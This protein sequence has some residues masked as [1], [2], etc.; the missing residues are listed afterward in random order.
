MFPKI[1]VKSLYLTLI[2]TLLISC[3]GQQVFSPDTTATSTPIAT[4]EASSLTTDESGFT[5][6]FTYDSNGNL[7]TS[8]DANGHTIEYEYDALN[9]LVSI[10]Y[11]GGSKVTYRYDSL[12]QRTSMTDSQ[13]TTSYEY[14]IHGQLV[15]VIHPNGQSLQY[16]YDPRGLL[17]QM[18][19]PDGSSSTFTWDTNGQLSTVQDVSGL[20]SY[21]Y[22]SGG[23]LIAR[24]LPNGVLT[25]YAYDDAS[26]LMSIQHSSASGELL[27]GFEYEFDAVGNRT[28]ERMIDPVGTQLTQYQYDSLNRLVGVTNPAGEM[29]T[30][31]YDEIGNRS[32]RNSSIM[33]ETTYTYN[34]LGQLTELN[35]PQGQVTFNYDS[36]GNLLE[37]TDMQ[38]QQTMEYAWDYNNRL[39]SQDNGMMQINYAY[40]GDG[41]LI[42]EST[43][44][45]EISNFLSD[46]L[47]SPGSILAEYD[48]TGMVGAS[49]LFGNTLI[50]ERNTNGTDSFFLEDGFGSI[51]QLVDDSGVT[52]GIGDLET[53][54]QSPGVVSSWDVALP[55]DPGGLTGSEQFSFAPVLDQDTIGIVGSEAIA[56]TSEFLF[57]ELYSAAGRQYGPLFEYGYGEQGALFGKQFGFV[58][59]G[60]LTPV[61]FLGDMWNLESSL[62]AQGRPSGSP[63]YIEGVGRAGLR[64]IYGT[65]AGGLGY[66]LGLGPVGSIAL[67][68]FALDV[69]DMNADWA[70]GLGRFYGSRMDRPYWWWSPMKWM[71]N[72][73]Y[74]DFLLNRGTT[75]IS[76]LS[77]SDYISINYPGDTTWDD[78]WNNDFLLPMC[79]PICDDFGGGGAGIGGVSLDQAAEVLV[80]LNEITGASFD[81]RTGQ[82]SLVGSQ[83]PSLPPMNMDDLVVAIR[84]IY[85]GGQD[86][87]VTMVP[88]DP[89]MQDITQRVEYFG[90]T[91][92][93]H[94]GMV[95][96]EADRY[97]KS[98]A[99][100]KDTLTGQ[101]V[102]PNVPGFK[103]ELDLLIEL[104]AELPWHRNWFVPGEIVISQSEDGRSMVFDKATIILQSRFFEFLPDGSMQDIPGSSPVTEQFTLFM[105]EHYDEFAA[106]KPE[107]AELQQLAKIVGLVRWLYDN[108]IPVD[109]SWVNDYQVAYVDTPHTT[110]GVIN[111]GSDDTHTVT[112]M[113]GVDYPTE[114]TYVEAVGDGTEGLATQVSSSRPADYPVSWEMESGGETL[115]AVAFNMAPVEIIGGYLPSV[116]DIS[117][118]LEGG[119]SATFTRMYNSLDLA[120]GSLGSGWS[121][122]IPTLNFQ[123]VPVLDSPSYTYTRAV[124]SLGTGIQSFTRYSD[125]FYYLEDA[126]ISSGKFGFTS[127][128]P[129]TPISLPE[130]YSLQS[131]DLD[132]TLQLLDAQGGSVDIGGFALLRQDGSV[133]SFDSSGNLT[134]QRNPAG[135]VV[136]YSYDADKLMLI[137]DATGQSLQFAYGSN[138]RLTDLV[139]S[140]GQAVHYEYDSAGNL[141]SVFEMTAIPQVGFAHNSSR[142]LNRITY[143]DR[144]TRNLHSLSDAT[145]I[146][147]VSYAYNSDGRL[148]RITTQN[149]QIV[150][151]GYDG[152]GRVISS[153]S[154]SGSW[155]T[156]FDTTSNMITYTDSNGNSITRQYDDQNRLLSETDLLGNPINYQYDP[157][158]ALTS[159][160]DRNGNTSRFM[161][162]ENGNL[163]ET[164]SPIGDRTMLGNYNEFGLPG[165]SIGPDN[166]VTL[167]EY[168]EAGRLIGMKSGLRVTDIA[169]DGS[170]G[171]LPEDPRSMS[172][173]YDAVGNLTGVQDAAG[174]VT[175]FSYDNLGNLMALQLP[176]D[177]G[178]VRQTYDERSRLV[179]I[180]DATGYQVDFGYDELDQLVSITTPAGQTQYLYNNGLVTAVT[181]P[182][183]NTIQ[184]G[185]DTIGRLTN[186]TEPGGSVT[187]YTYDASGN[188]LAIRNPQGGETQYTYDAAGRVTGI[189]N[190]PAPLNEPVVP[191]AAPI[192]P[193]KPWYLWGLGGGVVLLGAVLTF[194]LLKTKRRQHQTGSSQDILPS[195]YDADDPFKF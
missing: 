59:N 92:H 83:D 55:G 14:D 33:G 104:H 140:N 46:P 41:N 54:V 125:G 169:S 148:N 151:L 94:F 27:L 162:D 62:T 47:A 177:G 106:G 86:P 163:S 134:G 103:S 7:K 90:Q 159:F 6:L 113:G 144:S 91:E 191:E 184:Y 164:V 100:G 12:S 43:S 192:P 111:E 61:T 72:E 181:D 9:R 129:F 35:G 101:P 137:A 4:V 8:T 67:S 30:Y 71:S 77:T 166:E 38:S 13:G 116:T 1:L 69:A 85:G 187:T 132:Q 170:F 154:P 80:N 175:Q 18:E 45:G 146:P 79:P 121:Q 34:E 40:N 52:F 157:Q 49:L 136:T 139:T 142:G 75:P 105:N 68:R 66:T 32:A 188:L 131:G 195:S 93:T 95:M 88:V 130:G 110:P 44:S 73:Q 48:D 194:V 107:L 173:R 109:L 26:R 127:G 51:R 149:G 53:F 102:A 76:T 81:P 118:P 16:A 60:I 56:Q 124:I 63:E 143:T 161:Y 168:D 172:Y 150:E 174:L 99:S 5:A 117:V 87:G 185:Y 17:N 10:L 89:T 120:S 122:V 23:K 84:A 133:L 21:A 19:Y 108:N 141:S 115:T 42:S 29:V 147:L 70:A 171:Y 65:L 24:T 3:T 78:N 165:T 186:V 98:L 20:T 28:Q 57:K 182:S 180:A 179:S 138:D 128:D 160:A 36:I 64:M 176:G 155:T 152:L 74:E 156:R 193:S 114:N 25:S 82:V 22:D 15:K 96:F 11:P 119:E 190:L 167:F 153:D 145:E 112:I 123:T 178:E 2:V 97:L 58:L 183:N 189:K 31:Q 50:G 126:E 135:Q 39:I 158:G 37:W